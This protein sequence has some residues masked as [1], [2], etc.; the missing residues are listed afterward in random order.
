MLITLHYFFNF[1]FKCTLFSLIVILAVI[2]AQR[3]YVA[4]T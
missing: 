3:A 1:G 4:F 2:M